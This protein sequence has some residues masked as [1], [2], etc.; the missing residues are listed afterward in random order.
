[1]RNPIPALLLLLLPLS[2]IAAPERVA[3]ILEDQRLHG[4]P[5]SVAAIERLQSAD[6]VPGADAPFEATT[7]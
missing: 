5:S 1:M 3:E 7:H 4:Y 2:A 6:D